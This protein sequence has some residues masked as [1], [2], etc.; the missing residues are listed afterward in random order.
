[1]VYQVK[2]RNKM[3]SNETYNIDHLYHMSLV[4]YVSDGLI[5]DIS[6]LNLR[7]STNSTSLNILSLGNPCLLPN[8]GFLGAQWCRQYCIWNIVSWFSRACT[9]P[10]RGIF[11]GARAPLVGRC[12]IL[13]TWLLLVCSSNLYPFCGPES[14]VLTLKRI[15]PPLGSRSP[16]SSGILWIDPFP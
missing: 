10:W 5:S 1:M 16:C 7:G 15:L 11:S 9:C 6:F 14:F 4:Y 3:Y 8:R 12:G 13:H 2:A